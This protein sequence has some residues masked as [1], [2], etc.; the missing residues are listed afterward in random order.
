MVARIGGADDLIFQASVDKCQIVVA[1]IDPNGAGDRVKSWRKLLENISSATSDMCAD[2][3]F[4]TCDYV[5][6]AVGHN[7]LPGLVR[8]HVCQA[9]PSRHRM[10]SRRLLE[11]VLQLMGRHPLLSTRQL[12]ILLG[13][14]RCIGLPSVAGATPV[15]CCPR[16]LVD[17]LLSCPDASCS[18]VDRAQIT[19]YRRE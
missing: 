1:T 9:I 2:V 8:A 14:L 7:N 4:V 11:Q 6:T 16:S 15:R 18:V 5:A 17:A 19:G 3:R 13:P 10:T 12:A